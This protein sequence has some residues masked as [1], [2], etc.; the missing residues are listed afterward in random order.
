[1]TSPEDFTGQQ[2]RVFLPAPTHGLQ[3]CAH[4]ALPSPTICLS[5]PFWQPHFLVCL[6]W[7][8]GSRQRNP[9]PIFLMS[10]V[11]SLSL[12]PLL[13]GPTLSLQG[14]WWPQYGLVPA[15][16][17][18]Y[19]SSECEHCLPLPEL[20]VCW[21]SSLLSLWVRALSAPLMKGRGTDRAEAS[22]AQPA[23][24]FLGDSEGG[25]R[26]QT[27]PGLAL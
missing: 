13:R 16:R 1:M 20:K 25:V 11:L 2:V 3:G 23:S 22:L 12:N 10:V 7:L 14:P 18:A 24:T 21:H 15:Q 27:G 5:T 8:E 4:S 6:S 17:L 26:L 19:S 9:H